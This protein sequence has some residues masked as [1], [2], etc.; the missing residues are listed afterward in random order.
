M[1]VEQHTLVANQR[2]NF[3]IPGR[4][5]LLIQA[6]AA[7]DV[8]F[9][10]NNSR[11]GGAAVNVVAGYKSFPGDWADPDDNTF[12]EFVLTSATAQTVTVGV[13]ESAGDYSFLLA[14][15]QVEQPDTIGTIADIL[16]TQFVVTLLPLNLARRSAI[17]RNNSATDSIRIGDAATLS[18]I[19]GLRVAPGDAVTIT[20]T[21]LVRGIREAATD[22]VVSMVFESK[23]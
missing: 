22:V 15:V 14:L 5:F 7:I 6:S 4:F 13:S 21:E 8:E 9:R 16:V 12:D 17:I 18:N 2:A 1:R 20:G 23:A 11:I 19:R 10:R 3:R